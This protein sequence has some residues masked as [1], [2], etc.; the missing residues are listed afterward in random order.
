MRLQKAT[1]VRDWLRLRQ[2]QSGLYLATGCTYDLRI[3]E[4]R[5]CFKEPGFRQMMAIDL[6]HWMIASS[7]GIILT[8]YSYRS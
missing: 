2:S 1:L 3:D 8:F 6:L 4:E 5:I 7:G